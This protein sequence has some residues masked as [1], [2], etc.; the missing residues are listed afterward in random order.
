MAVRNLLSVL[1]NKLIGLSAVGLQ[2]GRIFSNALFALAIGAFEL[3]NLFGQLPVA[4][5]TPTRAF[6]NSGVDYAGPISLKS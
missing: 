5:L 4:R 1:F 6:L 2:Y 3:N